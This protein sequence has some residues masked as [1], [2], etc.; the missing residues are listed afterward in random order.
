M[1]LL[2]DAFETA[3]KRLVGRFDNKRLLALAKMK[4]LLELPPVEPRTSHGLHQIV[5]KVESALS[6]IEALGCPV[7]QWGLIVLLRASSALD[8]RTREDWEH[9]L[10][11]ST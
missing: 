4:M 7:E 11:A 1:K 2:A 6:A 3:W 10:G 8:A 5:N 9:H